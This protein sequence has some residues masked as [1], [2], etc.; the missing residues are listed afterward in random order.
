VAVENMTGHRAE[1]D[2]SAVPRC[3]YTHPE[4]ASVGMLKR[5]GNADGDAGEVLEGKFPFSANGKA[6]CLGELEWFVKIA[7]D[8]ESRQVIGGVIVGHGATEMI[9]ELSLAVSSRAKLED[10]IQAIHAH[11]TMHESVGEA[12]LQC[13]CRAIHL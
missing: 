7:A 11:P 3:V 4:I 13:L 9:A 5:P 8:R 2:Y 1:M 12:A 6:N 10:V